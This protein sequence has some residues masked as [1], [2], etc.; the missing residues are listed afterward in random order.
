VVLEGGL[1]GE[2]AVGLLGGLLG[3]FPVGGLDKGWMKQCE[4]LGEVKVFK[5]LFRM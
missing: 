2:L 4:K 3:F 1:V 5:Y